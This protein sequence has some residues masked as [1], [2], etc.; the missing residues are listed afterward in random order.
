MESWSWDKRSLPFQQLTWL[1]LDLQFCFHVVSSISNTPSIHLNQM[2]LDLL[3]SPQVPGEQDLARDGVG[4]LW[5]CTQSSVLLS[6]PPLLLSQ[7]GSPK[8]AVLDHEITG[9]WLSPSLCCT[10]WRRRSGKCHQPTHPSHLTLCFSSTHFSP[11][12]AHYWFSSVAST[13]LLFLQVL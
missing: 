13:L 3:A 10:A 12:L 6:V 8:A 11:V 5:V 1:G 4:S 9:P 2:L 7:E